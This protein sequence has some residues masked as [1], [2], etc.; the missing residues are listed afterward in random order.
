MWEKTT[1]LEN[2]GEEWKQNQKTREMYKCGGLGRSE[3][4]ITPSPQTVFMNCITS[5]SLCFNI[6]FSHTITFYEKMKKILPPLMSVL[7]MHKRR[8]RAKAT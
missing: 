8:S 4:T 7:Q 5:L 6:F 1:L 3:L 2:V